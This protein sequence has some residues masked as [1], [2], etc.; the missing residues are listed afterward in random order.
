MSF[1]VDLLDG[2]NLLNKRTEGTLKSCGEFSSFLKQLSKC[3]KAYA[4]SVVKLCKEQKKELQKAPPAEKEVG[5]LMA[6]LET[7][8]T[9]L[10]V[11]AEAHNTFGDNLEKELSKAVGDYVKDKTKVRKQLE[12]NSS[13]L[14]KDLKASHDN[15]GK[16]RQKYV[17]A[18]KEAEQAEQAQQKAKLD[19]TLKPAQ[20][21]KAQSKAQEMADKAQQADQTYQQTL[22][23]T[24][25]HQNDYYRSSMPQLLAE[26]Q[27]FEDERLRYFKD[28]LAKFNDLHAQPPRT[29]TQVCETIA[30]AVAAIDVDADIVTYVNDNKTNVVPPEDIVYLS[31]NT[32]PVTL[33]PGR[34]SGTGFAPEPRP[35]SMMAVK[36]VGGGSSAAAPTGKYKPASGTQDT[37]SN[38][39]W[40][41]SADDSA[42]MG[43][44]EQQAK[45][46]EQLA[47]LDRLVA[48]ETKSKDGLDNLVRFYASD[49]VAQRRAED[50]ARESQAKLE[51]MQQAR[52]TVQRQ[53]EQLSGSNG[54]YSADSDPQPSAPEPPA[55]GFVRVRGLFDYESTNDTELSFK[56]GDILIVTEQD[57]SGWWY[58]E[59]DGRAGFIPENYCEVIT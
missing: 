8:C 25:A 18:S 1:S 19:M 57:E 26:F 40:G 22:S 31:W 16:A 49:P 35:A 59:I 6:C 11:A 4:A 52:S 32:D 44:S 24:N 39:S 15:L 9:E 46:R 51:R 33:V 17:A 50:E 20:L 29:R 7:L 38:R 34:A 21:A 10:E 48:S 54:H 37:F 58:A 3:E 36:P 27:A 2:W 47:E 55:G 41:L 45:L 42:R 43:T 23:A 53:L 12:A 56:E 14:T 30:A 28:T 13:K 5:L